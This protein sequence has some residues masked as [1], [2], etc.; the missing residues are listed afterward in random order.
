MYFFG[1]NPTGRILNR[2]AKDVGQVDEK[3][4]SVAID[5]FQIALNILGIVAL[6]AVVNPYLILPTAAVGLIFYALRQ[7]Y[8]LSATNLKRMEA[9]S[10]VTLLTT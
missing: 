2:F 4:P 10:W 5:V 9:T 8:L 1:T 6:V 7:F 3:L